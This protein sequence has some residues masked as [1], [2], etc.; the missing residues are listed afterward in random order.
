MDRIRIEQQIQSVR[1]IL[2]TTY[3]KIMSINSPII[4][5]P[6]M[7]VKSA[8]AVIQ[9][10][11]YDVVVCGEVKKGKSSFI[12]ALM[13]DEVLPTNTQ[14]A[15]SQVFRIINDEVED[16]AL[17]FTNGERQRISRS[18]L[19]RYG[20][21]VDA[22]MY[23]EPIF[24][25]R[26][27]EYIEI[28]HPIPSLPK[29]VALIDTPGIGALYA[30]HEHI[31]RNYL[32]RASAVIFIVDPKNP[33]VVKEREFIESALG[34]T[35]QLMVVMT[36]MDNYDENVIATMISR[37]EDILSPYGKKT[38]TGRISIY[39]IS[40]TL[41]FDANKEK[42][43][44]LLE[45]SCFDKVKENLLQL[46]Y[47]TVGFGISAEVYSALN[48][49]NTRVIK[50]LKE[51]YDASTNLDE[52]K[53]LAIKKQD[54]QQ[55]FI[56]SWGTNGAKMKEI[57]DAIKNEIQSMENEAR[58]LFSQ[59]NPILAD[60]QTE[61]EDLSSLSEA[62]KLSKNMT[63]RLVDSYSKAWKS[64]M[65]ACE[66]EIEDI[67]I[68]YNANLCDV[69]LGDASVSVDSFKLKSRTFAE[70]LNAGRNS[71]FTGAFVAS[72]FATPLMIVAAPITLVIAGI[73]A[74]LG[75]G[76]GVLT[77]RDAEL[78]QLKQN[79]KEHLTKCYMQ[80]CDNFLV[81]TNNGKTQLHVASEEI[82]SQSMK[83]IQAIYEQHK[84]NLDNQIKMI[85]EKIQSDAQSRKEMIEK[86]SSIENQWKLISENLNNA[87][88]IL[89]QMEQERKAS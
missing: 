87:K 23:G 49:Y 41:L 59:T 27:L 76:A 64:I 40:S 54:A 52:A 32:K 77:K 33:I 24:K 29:S 17:V 4:P 12:N 73:G 57:S 62:Q 86:I 39:P 72:L 10:E 78:K 36:K 80:I 2:R 44:I 5:K 3:E 58:A 68:R 20:S 79:L 67:L 65:I 42:D 26:Q 75:I 21:Q 83:A 88:G 15:T 43:D 60:M 63:T 56:K 25:G 74:L 37:N 55:E 19:S 89:T 46:I 28:K 38:A 81:R 1:T 66:C 22:D 70:R 69:N 71:Y 35:K 48:N 53:K 50:S 7:S 11:Q 84:A 13:G 8:G 6:D 45:M 18:E 85:E 51:Q 61:I 16:Y 30:A 82:M 47:N 34:V 14:V 9:Q 31:T